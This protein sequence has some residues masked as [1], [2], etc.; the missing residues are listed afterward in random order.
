MG[1]IRVCSREYSQSGGKLSSEQFWQERGDGD[2][3]FKAQFHE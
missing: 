2:Y 3:E 1:H